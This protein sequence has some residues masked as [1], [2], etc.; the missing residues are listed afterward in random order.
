MNSDPVTSSTVEAYPPDT[1][2]HERSGTLLMRQEV[3][4]LMFGI[5]LHTCPSDRSVVA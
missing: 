1:I 4:S 5:L 3:L 2:Y